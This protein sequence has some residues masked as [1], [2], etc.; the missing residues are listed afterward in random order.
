MQLARAL[1]L[2]ISLVGKLT[3]DAL[4]RPRAGR[5]GQLDRERGLDVRDAFVD[6]V[7][8]GEEGLKLRPG[9]ARRGGLVGARDLVPEVEAGGD[10]LGFVHASGP[11]RRQ[12]V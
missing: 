10:V 12:P 4:G 1:L 7:V 6:R 8:L 3:P 2:L 5:L 11:A 9:L